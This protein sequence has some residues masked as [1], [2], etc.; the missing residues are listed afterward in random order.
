[1]LADKASLVN[2]HALNNHLLCRID[3]FLAHGAFLLSRGFKHP[4]H[5]LKDV[6]CI[7]H[8]KSDAAGPLTKKGKRE[9]LQESF[10][11]SCQELVFRTELKGER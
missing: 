1:M 4:V 3:S 5:F 6:L 8:P 7:K 11:Y 2:R 10:E 9:E